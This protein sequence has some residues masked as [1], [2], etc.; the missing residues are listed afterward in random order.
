[1]FDSFA[2]CIWPWVSCTSMT[3]DKWGTTT[4]CPSYPPLCVSGSSSANNISD[5]GGCEFAKCDMY[6]AYNTSSL[7]KGVN[8]TTTKARCVTGT[9]SGDKT[10]SVRW[11]STLNTMFLFGGGTASSCGVTSTYLKEYT[12]VTYFSG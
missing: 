9:I 6:V 10:F 11:S 2:A 3:F 1:M 8:G 5:D 12:R 7:L 4:S